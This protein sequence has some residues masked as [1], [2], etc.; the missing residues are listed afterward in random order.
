MFH[1]IIKK[2]VIGAH[3][4]QCVKLK[5]SQ[6]VHKFFGNIKFI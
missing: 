5:L 1:A 2:E 3:K 4:K 6:Q